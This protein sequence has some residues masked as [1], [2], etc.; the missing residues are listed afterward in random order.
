M[1]AAATAG[2]LDLLVLIS[3]EHKY[4]GRKAIEA[5]MPPDNVHG[6]ASLR[7]AAGF[8]KT[9][10]RPGDLVLL[11]GRTT[12][13]VARLF[14]A[15]VGSVSCWLEYCPKTMLCDGCWELGFRP[16]RDQPP[17]SVGLRG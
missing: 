17:P 9:E 5:G 11:K 3:R 7:D 15:Q 2:W 4:G 1:L 14:F 6:F 16:E 12:D 10:L 13:H 8:L